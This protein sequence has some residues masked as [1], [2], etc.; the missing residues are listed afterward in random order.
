ML[1][2]L[3]KTMKVKYIYKLEAFGISNKTSYQNF[4][5]TRTENL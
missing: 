5:S 2:D 1:Q 4:F 3:T